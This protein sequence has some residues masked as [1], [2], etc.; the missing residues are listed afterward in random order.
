[1]KYPSKSPQRVHPVGADGQWATEAD[2]SALAPS[3][4]PATA[5]K[6]EGACVGDIVLVLC[7]NR[8]EGCL[9]VES[10]PGGVAESLRMNPSTRFPR[11][12]RPAFSGASIDHLNS[13]RALDGDNADWLDPGCG[14]E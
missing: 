8:S 7:Q 11:L 12:A 13:D 2:P 3:T 1:M 14:Q 10:N 5:G 6:V 4:L 9:L